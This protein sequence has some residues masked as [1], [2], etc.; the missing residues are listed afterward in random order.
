MLGFVY[1]GFGLFLACEFFG[2]QPLRFNDVAGRVM[3]QNTHAAWW[4]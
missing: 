1:F 4:L 3:A 2:L